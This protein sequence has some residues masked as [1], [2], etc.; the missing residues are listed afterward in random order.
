MA[1]TN[2]SSYSSNFS[3]SNIAKITDN[4]FFSFVVTEIL[5]SLSLK[6]S[7]NQANEAHSCRCE[8]CRVEFREN[9]SRGDCV[10]DRSASGGDGEAEQYD[11]ADRAAYVCA[12][13]D[14]RGGQFV[15]PGS[16]FSS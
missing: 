1:K 2:A 3:I 5:V 11:E 9:E 7:Q 13:S 14:F 8:L 4:R 12:Y 16:I 6:L 15:S 10:R